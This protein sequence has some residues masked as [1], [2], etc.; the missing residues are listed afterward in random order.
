MKAQHT[1]TH[2]SGRFGQSC[3]TLLSLSFVILLLFFSTTFSIVQAAP[4][5]I[6]VNATDGTPV[7][8]FRWL[9]EEDQTYPV[10]PGVTCYNGNYADCQ[11]LNFHRSYM[12]VVA[13]GHSS[14]SMPDLDPSKR[15]YISVLPDANYTIGGINVAV[16]AT[17]APV[18]V[19]PANVP[20]AQ[21][22]VFVFN[23]KAPINGV[24]DGIAE[25]GIQGVKITLEDAGGRYGVSGQ[26]I[27]TD[28][29]GN[30]LGTTYSAQGVVDVMGDGTITTDANGFAT[31]KNLAPA[32]YGIQAVPTTGSGLIQTSTIEGTKIVDAWVKPNE[33][34]YFL[35]FGPARPP[36]PHV[37]IGFTQQ[38]NNLPATGGA[39]ITGKITNLH[40]SRPPVF[41]FHS[42]TPVSGCWVGLNQAIGGVASGDALFAA[43]C[44]A[45]SNFTIPNVPEGT[46]QLVIWDEAL[47]KVIAYKAITVLATDSTIALGD[48]PVFS[49]FARLEQKVFNDVNENGI[50][51]SGEVAM[52]D[53]GTNIRWRDGTIYQAATTD[54]SGEAPYDAVFPF[55]HWLVAEVAFDRFKATG[56]TIRV[57][58]GGAVL[59]GEALNPQ[60]Q[61][62]NGGAG[63]RVETGPVLT[64]A[65]QVYA[66]QTNVIEWGKTP[67]GFGENGGIS[68]I[69]YYATTRAEDDPRYAGAEVWEPGIPRIQVALYQDNNDGAGGGPDG[70]IDDING[71]PGIQIADVD[72]APFATA[73][74]PFP[75]AED[76]DYNNNGINDAG[77]AI[78][79]VTSDS[80]DDNVP[81]NCQGDVFLADGVY[82]TDC[83]DG[84]RNFNQVRPGVF[85]GGYAFN[86][87]FPGGASSGSAEVSGL[88]S[89][90][91]IVA[92]GEHKVYKTLKEE[93]RHQYV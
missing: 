57:D 90:T 49:W 28:V 86:S 18:K 8:N 41:T 5:S 10:V 71:V 11:A 4:L 17:S 61:N 59:P 80:W 50:W 15:Y 1:C 24:P 16:G 69:V 36:G 33:P 55:F 89:G 53:Q 46:Y 48:V 92:S 47:G 44:D 51:D 87:Y 37:F 25:T 27:T 14:T 13:E 75:A 77:D 23:D 66:G 93:D 38:F 9:V 91:Y 19:G 60:P 82:P 42:G 31:I 21:I 84:L 26:Q 56:A 85:D 62:E 3:Q 34:P 29:Y 2:N 83:F 68:G 45:N 76:F 20:T 30:P 65:F 81:T 54:V 79:I 88:P 72:N 40:N 67:Y 52:P 43:A 6:T 78:Q 70:V 12:P 74:R 39:T 35:E 32:K 63:F 22:R 73:A 58:D 7:L 64:Q